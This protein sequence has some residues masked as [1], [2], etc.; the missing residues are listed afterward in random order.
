MDHEVEMRSRITRR[1]A[2]AAATP[3]IGRI[4]WLS[5][6][7]AVSIVLMSASPSTAA[8]EDCANAAVRNQQAA[9]GLPDCR[10]YE[11]VSP[12]DKNGAEAMPEGV[13]TSS[14]GRAITW[15]SSGAYA[16]ATGIN[17]LAQYAGRRTADGWQTT[18]YQPSKAAH[19]GVPPGTFTFI[20]AL[21]F[22]GDLNSM[23]FISGGAFDPGDQD[24]NILGQGALDVY[25]VDANGNSMWLSRGQGIDANAQ[26][27]ITLAGMSED[28]STVFMNARE[29]LVP[30]VPR[31]GV[32]RLYRWRNGT[33]ELAGVDAR[34]A[35]LSTGSA[36]GNGTTSSNAAAG[37]NTG[38]LPDSSAI[39]ADG[40]AFI[41]QNRP[42]RAAYTGGRSAVYLH[43]DGVGST[44]ISLSQRSGS[45][46]QPAPTGAKMI[47]AT[48]DLAKI[49]IQSPDQLSDDAPLGGGDYVYDR[50]SGLLRFSNPDDSVTVPLGGNVNSG[51]V[52]VSDDGSYVYFTSTEALDLGATI[53][54]RNLYVRHGDSTTFI[55]TLAD[56][57][58]QVSAKQ[59]TG[60]PSYPA[61]TETSISADGARL[62]FASSASLGGADTGGF[63]QVYLYD[64]QSNHVRC[65][66]CRRSGEASQGTATLTLDAVGA[67]SRPFTPRAITEDGRTIVFSSEDQLLAADGN[68]TWDVYMYRDG[69]LWLLSTGR[70][71]YPS[72][73]AG[74]SADG[75]DIYMFTR[76]SLAPQDVDG[77]AQD[78]YDVRVGG[79]FL[80]PSDASVCSGDP[81]QGTFA[82][83]PGGPSA[84]SATFV[85]PGD[86]Q[87]PSARAERV[88]MRVTAPSAVWG[89]SA[90][91]RVTV[92]RAGL[93]VGL[94]S[95]VRSSSRT[96]HTA[97][98]YRI[99]VKLTRRAIKRLKRQHRVR[100]AVRVRYTP[101]GG[102]SQTTRVVLV[103][104]QNAHRSKR[105]TATATR[106]S[107]AV[108]RP[109]A[110][111]SHARKGI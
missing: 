43:D 79:G 51:L 14:D 20:G 35:D 110:A 74:M 104:K 21:A 73:L 31:D 88:L 84:G 106:G 54:G 44:E 105:S 1:P 38:R 65:V 7:A 19:P 111:L 28:G 33:V 93:I 100:T 46:G 13:R 72:G 16:N 95:S 108:P 60:Q 98:T 97:G 27:D 29:P 17:A 86:E 92:P 81:C 87:E 11:Q 107:L 103:F 32:T 39:S 56:T 40:R 83:V 99:R 96:V 75:A 91:L 67:R 71:Q 90:T 34:G 52:Q 66:S 2:L 48:P 69:E 10:A 15:T 45:I 4:E 12:V 5:A 55:G 94:G 9:T 76:E 78:V 42:Y 89:S 18:A 49:Y 23:T 41:Y 80:A 8:A 6:L 57:D 47:A 70:S 82:P 30:G 25:R 26:A 50:A 3:Y 36:L 62:L 22:P 68:G 64:A 61:L 59:L 85:G 101:S 24:A 109:T 53:G 37:G 102:A 63:K 77:G 58:T